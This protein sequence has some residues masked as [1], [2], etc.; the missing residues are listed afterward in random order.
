[1][2]EK[3][4]AL[5]SPSSSHRWLECLPSA[6]L[7]ALE[8]M[9]PPSPYAAEGTEAHTLS[10]LKLSYML[11]KITVG[12]YDARFEHFLLNSQ[13]YNQEFNEYVNAYCQEVMTIIKED[14]KDIKVEIYLEDR[15]EFTDI[16]PEGSGTSDVLIVGPNFIHTIDLK[17]GKGV[18]V[19]AIGNPQLRLYTLGGL[20]KYRLKG[21]F[22]EARM[23]IIQPRLYDIST[24]FISVRDLNEWAEN[25]VKPRAEL[26]SRGEGPLAPGDH[27]KFCKRKGKCEALA[28]SQLEAAQQEFEIV[29]ADDNILE[30][31]NMTPEMLSRILEVAPK[32]I[33]WFKDVKSYATAAMINGDLKIPGYK[34]VE[35]KSTRILTNKEAIKELLRTNGFAEDDYMTPRELLGITALEKNIGKAFFGNLAKDYILKPTGNPTVVVETDKRPALD[36]AQLKLSGQEF[37]MEQ[38]ENYEE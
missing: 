24:D 1:M 18:A 5:L 9:Q 20:K 13:F 4:H 38:N 22:T 30:P 25:Y 21:V 16:V 26:A 15:V 12:E 36:T 2:A 31:H 3:G 33:D 32:F 37:D 14:Y 17:F 34:V 35:G 8:P 19:S 6:R 11:D 27:C 7:E 28:Q 10:E 23:T 29:V